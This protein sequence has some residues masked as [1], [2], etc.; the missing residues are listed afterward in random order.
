[1]VRGSAPAPLA[2][3]PQP[4][5]APRRP[6]AIDAAAVAGVIPSNTVCGK[7]TSPLNDGLLNDGLPL[8]L[9]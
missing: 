1:M 4:G 3:L 2:E 5:A 6:R 7:R 8:A 9:A